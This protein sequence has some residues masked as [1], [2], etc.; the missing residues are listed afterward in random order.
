MNITL[1]PSTPPG[2]LSIDDIKEILALQPDD[3]SPKFDSQLMPMQING[4]TC[5]YRYSISIGGEKLKLT[6]KQF[7]LASRLLSHAVTPVFSQIPAS[8]KSPD[9]W[10]C[11]ASEDGSLSAKYKLT[12]ASSHSEEFTT[13]S[14]VPI[15][16]AQQFFRAVDLMHHPFAQIAPQQ[17]IP[18]ILCPAFAKRTQMAAQDFQGSGSIHPEHLLTAAFAF[19][20]DP[21]LAFAGVHSLVIGN[22]VDSVWDIEGDHPEILLEAKAPALVPIIAA[23][24]AY[25]IVI[26]IRV[27]GRIVLLYH[28]SNQAWRYYDPIGIPWQAGPQ[29]LQ[30]AIRTVATNSS[31]INDVLLSHPDQERD[32]AVHRNDFVWRKMF[33]VIYG[34]PEYCNQTIQEIRALTARNLGNYL[35]TRCGYATTSAAAITAAQIAAWPQIIEPD[36]PAPPAAVATT[37]AH[38]NVTIFYGS[39]LDTHFSEDVQTHNPLICSFIEPGKPLDPEL[40]IATPLAGVQDL[41]SCN[42]RYVANISLLTLPSQTFFQVNSPP[43]PT[44]SIAFLA[45]VPLNTACIN[46]TNHTLTAPTHLAIKKKLYAFL[47][48]AVTNHHQTIIIPP[49]PIDPSVS[50]TNRAIIENAIAEI[51]K[52]LLTTYFHDQQIHIILAIEDKSA[53]SRAFNTHFDQARTKFAAVQRMNHIGQLIPA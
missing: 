29:A 25:N 11:D 6:A 43:Y 23:H 14:T 41:Q 44:T 48:H 27:H 8:S 16:A 50:K 47:N 12:D 3:G 19:C 2:E 46:A 20:S 22:P 13:R 37:P 40:V 33:A 30:N 5:F 15:T 42:G 21:Q 10:S 1:Q 31:P 35:A 53:L 45:P 34:R 52:E 39:S 49:L 4:R 7:A 32:D 26:P 36:L 28:F 18:T 9:A 24:S 51:L 17:P 38:S